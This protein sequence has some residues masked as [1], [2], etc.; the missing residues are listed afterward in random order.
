MSLMGSENSL[1]EASVALA[2]DSLTIGTIDRAVLVLEASE[3]TETPL[4]A[5]DVAIHFGLQEASR[6]QR[7]SEALKGTVPESLKGNRLLSISEKIGRVAIALDE[8]SAR[9]SP[10]ERFTH[11]KPF[12]ELMKVNNAWEAHVFGRQH[13]A[14]T[15][16]DLF[17]RNLPAEMSWLKAAD[18]ETF[19]GLQKMQLEQRSLRLHELVKTPEAVLD[20]VN[21]IAE[22]TQKTFVHTWLPQF[23]HQELSPIMTEEEQQQHDY[24]GELDTIDAFRQRAL[25]IETDDELTEEEQQVIDTANQR[26]ADGL[27][28]EYVLQ[29]ILHDHAA[30][31]S[32]GLRKMLPM[33]VAL[34]GA[35]WGVEKFAPN[36]VIRAFA[37]VAGSGDD[38]AAE[39]MSLPRLKLSKEK[40]RHRLQWFIPLAVGMVAADTF[41]DKVDSSVN[42]HLGGAMYGATTVGL[43][44]A[45]SLA[46]LKEHRSRYSELVAEGKV[47]QE[48]LTTPAKAARTH[49]IHNDPLRRGIVAGVFAGPAVAAALWPWVEDKPYIYVPLGAIEPIAAAISTKYDEKRLPHKL[50]NYTRQQTAAIL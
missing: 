8:S 43:S 23:L 12:W 48:D 24:D 30:R 5:A 20:S 21:R 46:S 47:R 35:A 49:Y 32:E 31:E 45:S 6:R 10:S 44:A 42:P 36:D 9:P 28:G 39:V 7:Y 17:N 27:A 38:I 33:L 11:D 16:P 19:A 15:K 26:L 1:P 18:T 37:K 2:E 50:K 14:S 34:S 4:T 41:V 29:R 25:R 13:F 40:L 3:Q 22:D